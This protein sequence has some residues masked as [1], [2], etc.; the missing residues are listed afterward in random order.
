[1][2]RRLGVVIREWRGYR[3]LLSRPSPAYLAICNR[4]E[5]LEA[6]PDGAAGFRCDW[7]Y[8]NTLHAPKYFR[9]FGLNLMRRAL[10]DHPIRRA[11]LP[12][13]GAAPQVS[14][15]IGHRGLERLPHLLL[16]L[17]SIAGQAGADVECLVIEQDSEARLVGKLPAWVRHVHT[18]PPQAG[19]P[20][21]RSWTFN[22]GARHARGKLLV[23][24]DNDMLVPVD[25][26][27]KLMAHVADGYEVINPKRFIFYL[28][29]EHSAAIFA[30]RAEL[31][32]RA[33][34]YIVQNLEGGGSVAIT[35]E[36]Y[37]AIGGL[38]ESFVGWGGEDNEFWER[39][40]TRRTWPWAYLPLVH[41]WHA[42]QP[43]KRQP[44][45]HTM[46]RYQEL[47]A[48][49]PEARIEVLRSTPLGQQSGPHGWSPC[50]ARKGEPGVEEAS[51]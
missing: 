15:L 19:M 47:A 17:E 37:E 24:H 3:R 16:T 48:L 27:A 44:G 40:Q 8:S 51:C 20:Y 13:A 35:S 4:G 39:A 21:C 50:P 32:D 41:L 43:G 18:P 36:A 14:F 1:M 9:H 33:P 12:P 28:D 31:L 23:L 22:V 10:A 42:P 49:S 6:A 2:R 25:Y 45:Y 26:A 46:Q 34:E 38:D 7:R 5:R 29:Q 11:A 30:R